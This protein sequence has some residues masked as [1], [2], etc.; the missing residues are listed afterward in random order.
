MIWILMLLTLPLRGAV[1][2]GQ[3]SPNGKFA[4]LF[5]TRRRDDLESLT[6]PDEE[7]IGAGVTQHGIVAVAI[8]I[9]MSESGQSKRRKK[10]K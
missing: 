1:P 3:R 4:V 7:R 10:K 9:A 2:S 8:A 6:T 5:P